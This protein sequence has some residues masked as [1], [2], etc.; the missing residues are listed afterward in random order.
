MISP[1]KLIHIA[2]KWQ[3]QAA[4]K[5]KRISFPSVSQVANKGHFVVYT[6][7]KK[8]FAFPM[9]YLN[10]Y[11]FR[12]LL[13]MSEEEFGSP[14]DGPII[15]TCD[16]SLMEYVVHLIKRRIDREMEEALLMSLCNSSSKCLLSSCLCQE[17]SS[18]KLLV[19]SF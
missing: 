17:Q 4:L 13:A 14:G 19:C 2:R 18:H 3:R 11:V 5:R 12:Q 8:R 9:L 10:N 6:A 15:L 1:K 7:D 16:S